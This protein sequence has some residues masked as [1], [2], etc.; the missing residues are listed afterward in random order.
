[1]HFSF[2]S[3]L[4]VLATP[5][6]PARLIVLLSP[7]RS[8]RLPCF[9]LPLRIL[10]FS[11]RRCERQATYTVA[12]DCPP[13]SAAPVRPAASPVFFLGVVRRRLRCARNGDEDKHALQTIASGS[14]HEAAL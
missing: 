2:V 14:P 8:A 10:L 11:S 3:H 13:A 7:S 6:S 5:K 9:S 4:P 12:Y 1:M